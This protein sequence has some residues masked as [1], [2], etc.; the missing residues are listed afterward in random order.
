MLRGLGAGLALPLLDAM[1]PQT[2]GGG[3]ARAAVGAAAKV[4]GP[5]SATGAPLRTALIFLPNG[6]NY[7]NFKPSTTGKN[8]E[9]SEALMGL[10][11]VKNDFS[12]LSG[13]ALDGA[14]AHGD[15]GGDHARSAA[16]FLTGAHPY[17]T[18]GRNI[19]IGVS[20]D[21][22]IAQKVGDRT[23]LP[24][25]ELGLDKG[26]QAGGCDSGYACAYSNNVSWS[27][28]ATPVPKEVN[29]ANV[30]DRLFGTS[31]DSEAQA[32]KERRLKYRK[33]ILDFVAEDAARLNNQLG[34]G[35][36]AKM[37]EFSTSIRE[38]EKRIEH[39]RQ[40][41][42]Q[43]QQKPQ[44]KP[45]N[46]PRPNDGRPDN[47]EEHMKLMWDLLALAFQMD[48]TRVSTLMIAGDG[49]NRS[50]TNIGITEGHH[51]LSHHGGDK[52]KVEAIRKIDQFHMSQFGYFIKRLK[53]IKEGDATLLDHCI[54]MAG[55]GIGDGN[56]HNHNNLPI[57][58]AGKGNG[59]HSP[60]R[61]IQYDNDTPLC[62]LY[63][64]M[65]QGMGVNEQRFGDSTGVLGQL[66]A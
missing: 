48:V 26:A 7:E 53:S 20:I 63:L 11:D 54:V 27:S 64:G 61:H 12:L 65:L 52:E 55:A 4:G 37:D 35:D 22:V 19:K 42:L 13:L 40:L 24:S 38:I 14:K 58:L 43:E 44:P 23:R 1:I 28:E 9:L 2:I 18:S 15:G 59:M 5:V 3:I 10:K 16:A 32:A 36:K 45:D 47:V 6:V 17:K 49:S 66:K 25:L 50:Y 57:L 56:R 21:Q 30:F 46:F 39:T 8:Y 60:G 31:G 41:A 29:P 62:N 33:S 34:A 51:S